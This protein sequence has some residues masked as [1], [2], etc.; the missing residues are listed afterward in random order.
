MT[1]ATNHVGHFL[2]TNLLME[3]ILAAGKGARIIKIKQNKITPSCQS[4]N[5]SEGWVNENS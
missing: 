1:L 3:K 5:E 2:S 4:L